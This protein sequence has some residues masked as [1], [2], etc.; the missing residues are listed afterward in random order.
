MA[1]AFSVEDILSSR[2]DE[3]QRLEENSSSISTSSS[4]PRQQRAPP[5]TRTR[6]L[7]QTKWTVPE[8]EEML[9]CFSFSRFEGWG[10][11]KDQVLEKM[12]MK[13]NLPKEKMESSSITK[14]RSIVSQVRVYLEKDKIADIEKRARR[15]AELE[16][17]SEGREEAVLRKMWTG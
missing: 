2:E 8:K 9:Y 7:T 6:G 3:D 16:V 10:R 1:A 4:P 5:R 14:I 13:S 17:L 12:L 15:D 11:R